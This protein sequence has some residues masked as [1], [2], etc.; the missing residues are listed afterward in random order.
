MVFLISLRARHLRLLVTKVLLN[1][2]STFVA[3]LYQKPWL[4][5]EKE[6]AQFYTYNCFESTCLPN[7]KES[8]CL[9]ISPHCF[10]TWPIKS[11]WWWGHWQRWSQGVIPA[12]FISAQ[13]CH[14]RDAHA[15]PVSSGEAHLL[16]V[17]LASRRLRVHGVLWS[18][19]FLFCFFLKMKLT[20][21][22]SWLV[23]FVFK[24][25]LR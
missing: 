11:L 2:C 7:F 9:Q 12:S 1:K 15:P 8:L 14:W 4:F 3:L 20:G 19:G 10:F 22:K 17:T 24:M 25:L 18:G 6:H 21:R 16:G 5:P 23:D 13:S